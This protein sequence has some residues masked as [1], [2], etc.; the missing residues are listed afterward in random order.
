MTRLKLYKVVIEN[1]AFFRW[2]GEE[3]DVHKLEGL[4][5]DGFDF[6]LIIG[7]ND[8]LHHVCFY[9]PFCLIICVFRG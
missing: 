2:N 9:R 3:M 8:Q 4:A 5:E 6:A 7:D 1:R